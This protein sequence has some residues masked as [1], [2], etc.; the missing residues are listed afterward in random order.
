MGFFVDEA[1][2]LIDLEA[3]AQAIDTLVGLS[4]LWPDIRAAIPAIR[5]TDDLFTLLI[6]LDEHIAPARDALSGLGIDVAE[7]LELS[8]LLKSLWESSV[9]EALRKLLRP[10]GEFSEA[11]HG[12]EF[13]EVQWKPLKLAGAKAGRLAGDTIGFAPKLNAAAA[14]EVEAGAIAPGE[15]PPEVAYL[16]FGFGGNVAV[17]ANLRIPLTFGLLARSQAKAAA[18]LDYWFSVEPEEHADP[19]L[20]AAGARIRALPNPFSLHS[21]WAAA[22][23]SFAAARI[24]ASAGF[25]QTIGMR[26]SLKGLAGGGLD[27]NVI[28]LADDTLE[29]DA[30]IVRNRTYDM[31]IRSDKTDAGKKCLCVKVN[32]SRRI[33]Q[34]SSSALSISID[35]RELAERAASVIDGYLVD[36]RA[37]KN[38]YGK[39]LRPGT[40]LASELETE[41]DAAIRAAL[42]GNSALKELVRAL[43]GDES[44]R[45]AVLQEHLRDVLVEPPQRAADRLGG[46]LDQGVGMFS[47]Q[48]EKIAERLIDRITAAFGERAGAASRPGVEQLAADARDDLGELVQRLKDALAARLAEE[49]TE[50]FDAG[51]ATA[52]RAFAQVDEFSAQAGQAVTAAAEDLDAALAAVSGFV[53]AVDGKVAALT[54]ALNDAARQRLRLRIGSEEKLSL[55]SSANLE[56]EFSANTAGTRR[57]YDRVTR[58]EFDL[59]TLEAMRSSRG[60]KALSGRLEY[61]AESHSQRAVELGVLSFAGGES[62]IFDSRVSIAADLDGNIVVHSDMAAAR[63]LGGARETQ[64]ISFLSP[65]DLHTAKHTRVLTTRLT[66]SQEDANYEIGEIEDFL[67]DF[68][69]LELISTATLAAAVQQLTDWRNAA[70]NDDF[71]ARVD[72]SLALDAEAIDTLLALP[73]GRAEEAEDG[74]PRD[75]SADRAMVEIVLDALVEAGAFERATILRAARRLR[76]ISH[77]FRHH[78]EPEDVFCAVLL[79]V[80][81]GRRTSRASKAFMNARFGTTHH[82]GGWYALPGRRGALRHAYDI[83]VLAKGY[84]VAMKLLKWIHDLEPGSARNLRALTEDIDAAN[85]LI[86]FC[87]KPWLRPSRRFLWLPNDEIHA[88][89]HAFFLALAMQSGALARAADNESVMSVVLRVPGEND[90]TRVF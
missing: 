38:R 73:G 34:S 49:V 68:A 56:I 21:L 71:K 51:G 52:R 19:F 22:E 84:A 48:S 61:F 18:A 10:I 3:E 14:I 88:V 9:P 25:S 60:A 36:Y 86:A 75:A 15:L 26:F 1:L 77:R 53:A 8:A 58:G 12:D 31:L 67:D 89:S 46:L 54:T 32:R 87:L 83:H 2:N 11:E 82:H 63:R 66:A 76:A 37:L 74:E 64:Q 41:L 65:F 85:R 70:G 69:R 17:G 55:G 47:A 45:N 78:T 35:F 80:R 81:D 79:E 28:D 57:L 59:N 13:G 42:R 27:S 6:Q 44:A 30:Q 33:D 16:R 20:V 23:Q 40:L 90:K 39:Y 5:E 4:A 62:S 43:L 72:I 24:H 7:V 50:L 29:F